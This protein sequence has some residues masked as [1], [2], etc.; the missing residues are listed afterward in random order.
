[1]QVRKKVYRLP[2][3]LTM[4]GFSKPTVYRLMAQGRFPRPVQLSK[5][6]VGWLDSSLKEYDETLQVTV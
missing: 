3:V 5:R 1:M 2:D 6:A 4:Y